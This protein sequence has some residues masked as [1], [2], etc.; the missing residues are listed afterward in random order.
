[1]KVSMTVFRRLRS[2]ISHVTCP[3]MQ[4][5]PRTWVVN[6]P[7]FLERVLVVALGVAAGIVGAAMFLYVVG[8]L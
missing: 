1:M 5:I 4:E 6:Q 7:S 3:P 8:L 2:L